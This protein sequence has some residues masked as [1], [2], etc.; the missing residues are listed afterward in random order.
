MK[1]VFIGLLVAFAGCYLVGF[2][3]AMCAMSEIKP[4]PIWALPV[5][6]VV[7]LPAVMAGIFTAAWKFGML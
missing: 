4:N 3:I 6:I 2:G 7:W 5:T 1:Q